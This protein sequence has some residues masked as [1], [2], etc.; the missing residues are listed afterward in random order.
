MYKVCFNVLLS[1]LFLSTISYSQT[2]IKNGDFSVNPNASENGWSVTT[3]GLSATLYTA[4]FHSTPSCV[5]IKKS[6]KDTLAYRISQD[7]KPLPAITDTLELSF[8]IKSAVANKPFTLNPNKVIVQTATDRWPNGWFGP[9]GWFGNYSSPMTAAPTIWKQFIIPNINKSA[10]SINQMTFFIEFT[11]TAMDIL[12]DDVEVYKKGTRTGIRQQ[13]FPAK[14]DEITFNGALVMFARPTN[15]NYE[16]IS[17][18]GRSISFFKGFGTEINL[19]DQRLIP[20]HYI[21]KNKT[22]SN[23]AAKSFIIDNR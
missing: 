12:L 22:M 13:L 15:Y 11:D 2:Y 19:N 6:V 1:T 17:T 7:F 21:L 20:G 5:R 18:D 23:S 8:W 9:I 10:D 14:E 3:E 4:D 16:V